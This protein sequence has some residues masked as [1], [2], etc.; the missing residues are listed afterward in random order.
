MH[1]ARRLEAD[2]QNCEVPIIR[3]CPVTLRYLERAKVDG[4]NG[5][6]SK[7]EM[8]IAC[9]SLCGMVNQWSTLPGSWRR[10]EDGMAPPCNNPL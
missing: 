7:V 3:L 10:L 8:D 2:R 4:S 6:V 9:A 5:L 1:F